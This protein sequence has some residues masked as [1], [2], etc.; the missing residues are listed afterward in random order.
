MKPDYQILRLK[1]KY[2]DTE[3][4]IIQKRIHKSNIKGESYFHKV[5]LSSTEIQ[6]DQYLYE[7]DI[8]SAFRFDT[9]DEAK[10][11]LHSSILNDVY[12]IEVVYSTINNETLSR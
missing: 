2:I 4:Y 7:G 11:F 5:F 6:G 12:D 8:K 10:N 9:L 3:Y 1:N